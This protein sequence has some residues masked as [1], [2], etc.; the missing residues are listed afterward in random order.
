MLMKNTIISLSA[1]MLVAG[2]TSCDRKNYVQQDMNCTASPTGDMVELV[3]N[4]PAT[5][6]GSCSSSIQSTLTSIDDSRCPVDVNCVWA[7]KVSVLINLNSEF[8]IMLEP[9]KQ[10]DTVYNNT[11]YSFTL[12]DVVPRPRSQPPTSINEQK[13]IVRIVKQ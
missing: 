4:T 10:K 2:L 9:G 7:G 6:F 3:Y 1:L 5:V 13:A 11:G 12:V 8:N